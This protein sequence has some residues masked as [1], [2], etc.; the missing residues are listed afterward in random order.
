MGTIM[1]LTGGLGQA[2][3]GPE[4][5][6]TVRLIGQPQ[7]DDTLNATFSLGMTADGAAWSRVES[8]DLT[9]DKW[10]TASG[11][12][13]IVLNYRK[14]RVA[15]TIKSSGYTASRGTRS[16]LFS[17]TD[18]SEDRRTAFRTLLVGSPA[19]RAFRALTARLERREG[20]DTTAMISALV[21]GAIVATLDGDE[22][23]VDRVGRRFARR[24]R[25]GQR[26]ASSAMST[27]SE[28]K[29]CVGMYERAL[30]YSWDAYTGC[31][32]TNSYWAYFFYAPLCALEF[33][34]RSQQYAYQFIACMAIPS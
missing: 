27:Q 7:H 24:I 20:P 34:A 23:A 5:N 11:D 12:A 3:A 17:P 29:D 2:T 1:V 8:G 15:F 26:L 4:V 18:A 30:M 13:T 10:A 33:G 9:V 14:D 22:G 32:N 28:F 25:A 31:L 16:A 19:V 21:D 6:G